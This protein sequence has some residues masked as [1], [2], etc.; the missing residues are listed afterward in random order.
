MPRAR[1][2]RRTMKRRF[3]GGSSGGEDARK[4]EQDKANKQAERA[5][6]LFEGSSAVSALNPLAALRAL[7]SAGGRR[8]RARRTK[9]KRSNSRRRR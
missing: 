9:S 5:Q 8:S 6:N 7:L 1:T 2:R 4:A 3:R